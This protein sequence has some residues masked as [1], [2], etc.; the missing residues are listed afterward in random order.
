MIVRGS[1]VERDSLES[2][3]PAHFEHRRRAGATLDNDGQKA[4]FM[5]ASHMFL[6][7]QLSSRLSRQSASLQRVYAWPSLCGPVPK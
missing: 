2:V 5:L 4:T 3:D 6:R 7:V 1:V